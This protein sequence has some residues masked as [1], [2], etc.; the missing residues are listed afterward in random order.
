[1]AALVLERQ[2]ANALPKAWAKKLRATASDTFTVT[3]QAENRRSNPL[4]GIWQ[5]RKDLDVS[6]HLNQLRQTRR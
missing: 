1:M 5:D 2:K 3:I 4:F 6:R